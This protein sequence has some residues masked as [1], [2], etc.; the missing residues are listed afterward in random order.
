[1]GGDTVQLAGYGTIADK[2][3][4]N[5]AK[6]CMKKGELAK[7]LLGILVGGAIVVGAITL[8]GMA[9]AMKPFLRKRLSRV[10][11]DSLERTLHKL[12][13]RRMVELIY[14]KNGE[15]ALAITERGKTYLKRLEFDALKLPLPKR[16]DKRW[17]VI[18]FDIP[19]THKQARDALRRKLKDMGC[20]QFHKSVFV[21]PAPCEDEVDFLTELFEI[22]RFV[23]V[24]RTE[25]LGHQ[26][27]HA[28]RHF[29]LTP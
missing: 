20:F 22:R 17:S 15:P 5:F 6:V 16:W 10:R 8:P 4:T 21:H 9:V 18:L 25:S 11:D 14:D 23:T 24:F 29:A 2:L 7:M 13:E 27:H 28:Y 26:E 3:F 12:R 19:E 1:M